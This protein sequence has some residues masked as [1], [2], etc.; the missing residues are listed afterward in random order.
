MSQGLRGRSVPSTPRQ[1]TPPLKRGSPTAATPSKTF[2]TLAKTLLTLLQKGLT[3]RGSSLGGWLR[4]Y[5]TGQ[6]EV[7]AAGMLGHPASLLSS[8]LEVFYVA[9]PPDHRKKLQFLRRSCVSRVPWTNPRS[10]ITGRSHDGLQAAYPSAGLAERENR[11][12][13]Y[14]WSHA[15]RRC[16]NS[17]QA[18]KLGVTLDV[19][20]CRWKP[21]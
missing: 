4:G 10:P 1:P 20:P 6:P 16:Y 9:T 13:G 21:R 17:S 5:A 7:T 18:S 14:S 19:T 11:S 3:S 15:A 12:Q 8:Y 2:L